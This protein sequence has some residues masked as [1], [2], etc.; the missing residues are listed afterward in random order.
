M[1]DRKHRNMKG[2]EKEG[3][4]K[5]EACP[6]VEAGGVDMRLQPKKKR[7]KKKEKNRAQK[8]VWLPLFRCNTADVMRRGGH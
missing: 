1:Y 4:M 6:V 8:A 2:H 3:P 5:C 7:E